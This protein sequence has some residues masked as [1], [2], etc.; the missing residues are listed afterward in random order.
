MALRNSLRRASEEELKYDT[1]VCYLPIPGSSYDIPSV[2]DI[3]GFV[4]LAKRSYKDDDGVWKT[5][6]EVR[7]KLCSCVRDQWIR[8]VTYRWDLRFFEV[9]NSTL[10]LF[11]GNYLQSIGD[12][13]FLLMVKEAPKALGASEKEIWE[14]IETASQASEELWEVGS[15]EMNEEGLRELEEEGRKAKELADKY[16]MYSEGADGEKYVN[17]A[18]TY[19]VH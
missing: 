18:G 10:V 19:Y 13:P 7:G 2:R 16:N 17:V 12:P 4:G 3:A 8:D 9:P 11:D 5:I 14:A 6:V 1:E 15:T